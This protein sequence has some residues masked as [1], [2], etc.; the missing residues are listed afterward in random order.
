MLL[1]PPIL[2]SLSLSTRPPMLG[3]RSGSNLP[4]FGKGLCVRSLIVMVCLFARSSPA[5]PTSFCSLSSL[6]SV[7]LAPLSSS[8]PSNG[9]AQCR[10]T[11]G[12]SALQLTRRAGI[13]LEAAVSQSGNGGFNTDHRHNKRK[14]TVSPGDRLLIALWPKSRWA[15]QTGCRSRARP[16]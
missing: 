13:R 9:Y 6:A 3:S 1:E 7:P 16:A 4:L 5:V 2:S 10:Q 12:P 11:P 15:A 14:P 8:Q